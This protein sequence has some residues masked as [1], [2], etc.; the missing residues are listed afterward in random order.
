MFHQRYEIC[1]QTEENF[2][3]RFSYSGCHSSIPF[4]SSINST[5]MVVTVSSIKTTAMLFLRQK[6]LRF[7]FNVFVTISVTAAHYSEL[8][9][10]NPHRC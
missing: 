9:R 10:S 4:G 7:G 6:Y 3:N 8:I 5:E 1:L 2:E